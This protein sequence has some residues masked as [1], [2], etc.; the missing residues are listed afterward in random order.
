MKSR[1]RPDSE[2]PGRPWEHPYRERTPWTL[3]S[4]QKDV[5]TLAAALVP[6]LP[7]K[8]NTMA[9]Y[10]SLEA[11]KYPVLV[12][13]K[14]KGVRCLTLGDGYAVGMDLKPIPNFFI[15]NELSNYGMGGLDGVLTIEGE[16]DKYKVI[17]AVL[18][19]ADSMP[20]FEYHVFDLWAMTNNDYDD[21]V[22]DLARLLPRPRPHMVRVLSP[23]TAYDVSGLVNFWNKCVDE[24][25]DGVMIRQPDGQYTMHGAPAPFGML[26]SLSTH[27]KATGTIVISKGTN[28]RLDAFVIRDRAGNEFDVAHGYTTAQREFFWKTRKQHVGYDLTYRY[29]PG[30]PAPRN[31]VFIKT[32]AR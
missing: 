8:I 5:H 17:D 30:G 24:G 6:M 28:D 1:H 9:L 11:I 23:V 21:R 18:F 2:R 13:P 12:T 14:V 29:N 20:K 7:D 31:P 25:Y 15:R 3:E 32:T 22:A 10:T 19:D 26:D 27:S 4:Y 16:L